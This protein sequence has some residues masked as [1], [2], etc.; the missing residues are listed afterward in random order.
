MFV[1]EKDFV[2]AW[3]GYDLVDVSGNMGFLPDILQ[4]NFLKAALREYSLT[5]N[6]VQD[7]MYITNEMYFSK[8]SDLLETLVGPLLSKLN[9]ANALKI[10]VH[11]R[12][13]DSQIQVQQL[14]NDTEQGGQGSDKKFISSESR[15]TNGYVLF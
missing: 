12:L 7:F 13:G 4:N 14:A 10:G 3:K 11:I 8:P 15:Y 1:T 5:N 9:T 2:T 6:A